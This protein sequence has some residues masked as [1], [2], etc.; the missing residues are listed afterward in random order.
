M[1][2]LARHA[3]GDRRVWRVVRVPTVAEEDA[4]QLPRTLEKLTADR[5]RLINRLKSLLVTQGVNVPIDKDFLDRLQAV[6]LWDDTPVPGGLRAGWHAL[7]AT[8]AHR[9]APPR[10]EGVADDPTVGSGHGHHASDH[11]ATNPASNRP[12]RR[13][14]VGDGDLRMARDSE[15]TSARRIGR[16]GACPVTKRGEPL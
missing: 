3:Q 15:W 8:A 16:L 4:R 10:T 14:D 7:G 13:L 9:D 12:H 6:R 5:T 1:S 11:E 2:L